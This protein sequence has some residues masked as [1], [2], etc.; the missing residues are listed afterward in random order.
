[1]QA[2]ILK[3]VG[4]SSYYMEEDKYYTEEEK[5]YTIEVLGA[6]FAILEFFHSLYLSI[7][8]T[9]AILSEVHTCHFYHTRCV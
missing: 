7:I 1:M 3:K 5:W 2:K 4:L 9:I 6:I 8:D